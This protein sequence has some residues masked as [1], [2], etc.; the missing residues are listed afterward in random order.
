MA[1]EGASQRTKDG[2]GTELIFVVMTDEFPAVSREQPSGERR[3]GRARPLC[4][5]RE[6]RCFA[7][8]LSVLRDRSSVGKLERQHLVFVS[9]S[10]VKLVEKEYFKLKTVNTQ[11]SEFSSLL[12][13]WF[14]CSHYG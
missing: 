2:K 10:H 7:A 13:F 1:W 12:W 11:S 3:R 4:G 14:A 8:S 6:R 9:G 5:W